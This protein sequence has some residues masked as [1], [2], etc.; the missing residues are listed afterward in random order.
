M[1]QMYY[2]RHFEDLAHEIHRQLEELDPND[3]VAEADGIRLLAT[4]LAR[5]FRA[6]NSRFDSTR[7]LEACG[8]PSWWTP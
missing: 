4:R 2:Q 8:I 3:E 1:A 6:D 7:F 5:R